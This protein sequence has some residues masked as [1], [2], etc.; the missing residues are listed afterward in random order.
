MK[1]V[2]RVGTHIKQSEGHVAP[3]LNITPRPLLPPLSLS[4]CSLFSSRSSASLSDR[5]RE[6]AGVPG[7]HGDD[8]RDQGFKEREILQSD[9]GEG[10]PYGRGALGYE[11]QQVERARHL[12]F[13]QVVTDGCRIRGSALQRRF[14][15]WT[16]ALAAL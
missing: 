6:D 1:A 11:S 7:C 2:G 4:S 12:E 9:P 15:E 8:P 5:N 16:S 14:G 3:G 10:G 13:D